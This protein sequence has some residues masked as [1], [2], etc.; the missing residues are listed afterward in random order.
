MS[1]V[2]TELSVAG[3][4]MAADSAISFIEG[5]HLKTVNR[6]MWR[7]LLRVPRIKAGISYWGSIGLIS[8]GR[9]DEWLEVKISG[10][11]YKDLRSFSD[12]LA[13]E[14]N[15][16]AGNKLIRSD[17][18]AGV[19]VAGIQVWSDGVAR[20]TFYHVHNGHLTSEVTVK[21]TGQP[22][23]LTSGTSSFAF[24]TGDATGSSMV[25]YLTA[26]SQ[27]G[28]QVSYDIKAQPRC[29]FEVHAD[30]AQEAMTSHDADEHLRAKYLTHNGD[31][32]PYKFIASGL[33]SANAALVNLFPLATP[34]DPARIGPRVGALHQQLQTVIRM[35]RTN[36][37]PRIIDGEIA[38]LGIRRDG[39]YLDDD[40][41]KKSEWLHNPP[42]T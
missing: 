14:L 22:F 17:A 40:E 9:F 15:K 30:F 32:V 28:S 2:L 36:G 24:P 3:I 29:R 25:P 10:G 8:Q 31:Y 26:A 11:E 35:Y 21:R 12:F 33:D 34:S 38:T 5:G 39:T 37:I 4:A 27:P 7:K 18:A 20:P 13:A 6:Q 23:N 1:L 41:F 19:H 16:A 42:L